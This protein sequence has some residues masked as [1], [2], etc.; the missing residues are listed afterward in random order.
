M[1][2]KNKRFLYQPPKARDLTTHS[3]SGGPPQ[4]SCRDGGG[5]TTGNCQDGSLPAGVCAPTGSIPQQG[6]CGPGGNAQGQCLS[7]SLYT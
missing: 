1:T 3:A 6:Y 2:K 7:G 4:Q 5:V